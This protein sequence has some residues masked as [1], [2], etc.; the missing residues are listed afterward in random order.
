MLETGRKPEFLRWIGWGYEKM[1]MHPQITQTTHNLRNL[2][3][4]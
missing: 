3:I 2:W 4:S 1:E